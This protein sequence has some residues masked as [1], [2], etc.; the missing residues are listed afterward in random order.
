MTTISDVAE[1][2]GVSRT[3]V[4][5]VLNNA[6]RVSAHLRERVRVAIDELGYVPNPRAKS[7]RTGTTNV[8]ALLIPDIANPF[9]TEVVRTTQHCLERYGKDLLVFN[10]DVPGGHAKQHNREYL[11]QI[12]NKGVDGLVIGDFAF[13]GMYEAIA[14]IKTPTV[15][16]GH[17]PTQSV[18]SV[19]ADDF[20]G[21]YQMGRYLVSA[22]HRRIAV[23]TGPS[24]FDA[25]VLRTN[26][27]ERGAA[28]A[29][30]KPDQ[31][32]RFEGSYLAPSGAAAVDWLM[33]EHGHDLPSVV[34]FANLLMAFGGIAALHDR[35][36]D[37]PSD[38]KVALFGDHTPVEFIRPKLTRVGIAPAKLAR[39]AV[40]M[41]MERLEG[42]FAGPARSLVIDPK[43]Q[44]GES[45]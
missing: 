42:R 6:D 44:L 27:F 10:S 3:T 36:L 34:F 16:I 40:D 2:A 45:A 19:R 22:G 12:H 30:L 8:I 23:V 28:E 18:D 32:L 39:I 5:H 35:G 41:L 7:L 31:L 1:R 24:N 38:I 13:H 11:A 25:A 4:S 29:G 26:G 43:M 37:I 21:S 33:D 15:F 17:L 20:G 9:Y 14:E